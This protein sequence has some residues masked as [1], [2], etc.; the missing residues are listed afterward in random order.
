MRDYSKN[1]DNDN[2]GTGNPKFEY[3]ALPNGSLESLQ[4]ESI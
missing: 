4:L 1:T 2:I 3:Y